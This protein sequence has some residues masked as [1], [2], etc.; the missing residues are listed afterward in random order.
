MD[1]LLKDFKLGLR[2]LTKKPASSAIAILA[3]GLGIGLC[4]TMF[5][6]IYGVYFRGIGVPEADRLA[7][8][9]RTNPSEN[10]DRMGVDQHDFYD[11]REQQ[12]VFEAIAGFSSGTINVSGPTDEPVRY[13][14]A[15]VSANVFDVLRKPPILGTSFRPGDDAPDAPMTVL[16]GYDVWTSRYNSDPDVIGQVIRVNGEQATILG[17]VAEDF[18]FPQT[19]Q[20]WI[21]RRDVRGDNPERGTGPFLTV[22]GRLKE[23]MTIEQATLD[24]SLVAQNLASQYPESNED[25]G[26]HLADFIEQSIG[27]EAIPIF[28]AMQVATIFV[29]LI[30]CA[31]VA[32]LLLA[33]AA[34]R[35]KEAAVR[36]ALGASKWRVALPQL[37]EAAVLAG[38]GALLG[39]IIAFVGV[40]WC[41]RATVG[42]GR[43]Y[44]M[45]LTVDLPILGF[46][47][48]VT[49]L[50]AIAAG[51]APAIQTARTDVNSILK[52]ENRGSSSFR[53]SKLSKVLIIGEVAM[54]C[55]LL[56]GAGLM[57]KSITK[58]NNH[59]FQFDTD[60]IFSARAGIFEGDYPTLEDRHRFFRE[61]KVRLEA[62]PGAQSVALTDMLPASC[63]SRSRFALEGETYQEDQDYPL[64]N[65][66]AIS[67]DFFSTFGVQTL[68]GRDLSLA[69]DANAA[70]VVLINQGFADRYFAGDDPIGRRIRE[71]TSESQEEWRTIVGVVPNMQMEGFDTE[72]TDPAGYYVPL[73][74]NDS[75]FIS[76]AIQVAGGPPLN[77][78]QDVRAAVR[79]LDPNL[80]VYWIRDMD[81]VIHQDTWI[82]GFFGSLFIAF[83]IAAL[84]LASVGLYGVLAFSVS[85]RIQ[86]M[87]LRMALGAKAI[88]VIRLIVREG[89]IQLGI[90]LTLGIT[91]ALA[92]SRVVAMIMW[93]VQ[94]RDP[95]VFATIVV[96]I[97]VVG[98]LASLIPALRATRV[99]PGVALR[100]D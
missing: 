33:R 14:G 11:W 92:V 54:S 34:L 7:L 52:D 42:V 5:S 9:Y 26:V 96:T 53:A 81:E 88:D 2:A 97:L 73:A 30:A 40:E 94:P 79:A 72:R 29:L 38:A 87:G 85:R 49:A 57:A 25:I 66:A 78:A 48:A 32:N 10:I 71:G 77:I 31:N 8:I 67:T 16:I 23:G 100:Y 44:F 17:V 95:A 1:A 35:T 63:C 65:T 46:I 3:F 98:I 68:R 36:S 6:L 75:R 22:F 51:A 76:I 50:T 39:I 86:E 13:D 41:D 15:F 99:D 80:P 20:I 59:E 84:F 89:A 62:V 82:Y 47:L 27:R 56:V 58:L 18:R 69:D 90:G 91:L 64:V 4:A 70:E 45:V 37:S 60:N 55:A 12:R 28:V 74:Q 93:D 43:P 83:G 24:M 19:E 61:L 21:P